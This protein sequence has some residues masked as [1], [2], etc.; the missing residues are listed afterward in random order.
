[1]DAVLRGLATYGA[2]LIIFR[3]TGKRTLAQIT[4][5]DFVLLLIIS[6]TTQQGMIGQDY[7]ITNAVLLV[8]TLI[9][10]DLL[11]NFLKQRWLWLE[12]FTEGEPLIILENG[13]LI[14]ER[15]DRLQID[16]SDVLQAARELQGLERLDQIKYA[17]LERNG[18][19]TVIPKPEFK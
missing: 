14:K 6:E 8:A 7:S 18:G 19:I 12:R 2:V 4:V 1:M 5:F 11:L 10:T 15:A 16:E 17:V 13:Q 9:S 3:I